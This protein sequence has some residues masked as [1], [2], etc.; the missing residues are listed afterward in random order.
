VKKLLI[1]AAVAALAASAAGGS[2]APDPAGA[3]PEP[4]ASRAQVASLEA[5]ARDHARRLGIRPPEARALPRSPERLAGRAE[6]LAHVIEFLRER[7]ERDGPA[8]LA[9]ARPRQH[10]PG[11]AGRA[12]RH[13][14][15]L[16]IEA[17]PVPPPA[18]GPLA[19]ADETRRWRDVSAWL[20]RR[21]ER[22][23]PAERNAA[24]AAAALT[25]LGTPYSYGG[26]S[27]SSG[28]DCSGLVSWAYAQVGV[29]LPH[30]TNAIWGALPKVARGKMRPGD[31]VFF[32]GLGH[33]GIFLG[34]G[35]YV[36]APRSGEVVEVAP[37]GER[38]DF[39]GAVRAA[40]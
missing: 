1:P 28:F 12:A 6:R 35:R 40:A 39:L 17:P 30:N 36:H 27:P 16:G 9:R 13:A 31:M 14:E 22:V 8:L 34:D 23:R 5:Q 29:S 18:A 15:R 21:S 32:N 3:T 11:A 33:M 2:S 37:L 24:A 10:A 19:Q 4:A 25:Q 20:A 26:G 38:D 7:E